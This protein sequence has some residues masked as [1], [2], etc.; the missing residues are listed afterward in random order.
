MTT[1]WEGRLI[2]DLFQV[3]IAIPHGPFWFLKPLPQR[4]KQ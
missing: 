2:I 4:D 3:L 1:A